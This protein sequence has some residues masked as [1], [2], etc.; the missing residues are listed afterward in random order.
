VLTRMDAS[1]KKRDDRHGLRT[2][3]HALYRRE[4]REIFGVPIYAMN[5]LASG[6]M[7]P[8]MAVIMLA[9]AGNSASEL[10]MLPVML[11]LVPKPLMTAILTGIFCLIASMNMAVSTAVSREGK[12]HEFFRT[13]PVQPQQQMLA[14]LFMGL[15]ID[16]ITVV[17]IALIAFFVLPGFRVQLTIGFFASALFALAMTTFALMVD[18]K[19][20]KFGWKNETEAIKQNGLAALTMFGSM[21]F[22]ALCGVAYFGLTVIGVSMTGALWLLCA[23]VLIMDGRLLTRLF[24]K[25]SQT[26][27]L[28][29]VRI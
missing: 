25:T 2:P 13:L 17:P 15:T 29:E 10:A 9:G 4:L 16:L 23:L 28:Q 11:L 27:I 18:A 19:H 6:V 3:L 24:K 7:F 5:C 21:G 8:V 12:R 26:Y 22:I 20:P 1:A 14:K